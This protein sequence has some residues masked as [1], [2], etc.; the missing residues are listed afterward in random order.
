MINIDADIKNADWAKRTDDSF[1]ALGISRPQKYQALVDARKAC[2]LCSKSGLINASEVRGGTLDAAVQMG[3]WSGWLGDLH[4]RVMIVGQDWGDRRAFEKQ[5]GKNEPSATNRM[6]RELLASIGIDV[7][8]AGP[9]E[10]S[11][12]FLTNAVLCFRSEAGCQGP[13]QRQWFKN[14]GAQFLRPQI[15]LIKPKVVVCLGE[16]AY[17]A[18]LEAYELPRVPNWRAAVDGP[19]VALGGG[20]IAFAVYHC[21]QRILNT[22]RN[23]TAQFEDWKR[24]GAAMANVGRG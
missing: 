9:G 24:I 21:G 16:R 19:G 15:D 8:E 12:V 5:L 7:P 11:G 4:A 6:L 18:V 14:C 22:H 2:R 10:S 13:V 3:P 1:E 23:R 20:P 17:E